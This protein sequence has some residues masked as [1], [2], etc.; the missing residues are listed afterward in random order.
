MKVLQNLEHLFA[1]FG[2]VPEKETHFFFL[3]VFFN[4]ALYKY[5]YCIKCRKEKESH[6]PLVIF[7]FTIL[8]LCKVNFKS[9]NKFGNISFR[10]VPKDQRMDCILLTRSLKQYFFQT[11]K[12]DATIYQEQIAYHLSQR[13]ILMNHQLNYFFL[14]CFVAFT[15][16]GYSFKSTSSIST[17]LKLGCHPI[18]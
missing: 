2:F 10:F 5:I 16:R 1:S 9:C 7:L 8:F 13:C 6:H 3:I 15:N 14:P 12:L 4:T 18:F 17:L 11:N